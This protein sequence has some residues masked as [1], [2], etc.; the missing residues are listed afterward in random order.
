MVMNS[1]P[2]YMPNEAPKER[3]WGIFGK[4]KYRSLYEQI[5]A[6]KDREDEEL[7]E[8]RKNM[9]GV[10]R[11]DEEEYKD[12]QMMAILKRK[13]EEEEKAQLQREEKVFRSCL[14]WILIE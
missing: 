2:L 10:R 12:Y 8:R 3:K 6:N 5:K 4:F 9:Y 1:D 14:N 13:R 11:M 7:A